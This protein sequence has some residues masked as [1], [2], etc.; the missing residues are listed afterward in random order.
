MSNRDAALVE[1]RGLRKHFVA[2]GRVVNALNG[3]DLSIAAG[4]AIGLVGE[5]GCG[6]TTLGR[7]LVGLIKPSAGSVLF[8]GEDVGSCSRRRL[9]E[10][11]RD[12]QILFQDPTTALNPAWT[13]RSLLIEPLKLHGIGEPEAR[14]AE[15]LDE[16]GLEPSL[17]GRRPHELSGGQRQRVALARAIVTRPRL[18]VLDEP[19]ASVDMAMRVSLLSMLK[20]LQLSHDVSYLLISHDLATVRHI[21]DRVEVMYLGKI[22]ERGPTKSFFERPAHVYC[23]VLLDAVPVLEVGAAS[24][25]AAITGE[26]PSVSRI[27]TGCPFQ[28]RCP[29]ATDDCLLPQ[30]FHEVDEKHEAACRLAEG[31]RA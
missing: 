6:K 5:S 4:E 11:R 26:P 13:V 9:R 14:V 10:L 8:R 7:C 30:P 23:Q 24:R 27:P 18:I 12:I 3:I 15:V 29:M 22:V 31:G 20:K 16:V 28:P 17:I 21:C 19:T 25:R 1:V 2:K